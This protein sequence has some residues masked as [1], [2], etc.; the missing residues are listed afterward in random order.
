L[1]T[2]G[3]SSSVIRVRS[4]RTIEPSHDLAAET[5]GSSPDL[6][7]RDG[8]SVDRVSDDGSEPVGLAELLAALSLGI[9]LGFGQPMEHVLR[10]CRIALRI[11]E[12]LDLDQDDRGAVYYTALLINVGCHTDAFEQARWFGDDIALKSTKYD[13]EP[14]SI[15]DI[16]V[17]LRLLGSGGSPLHRVRVAFDFA[18]SGR[19]ELDG[20]IAGHAMAA[21]VLG[22]QLGLPDRVLVGL[23]GSYER[24]DG[25]GYP[26]DLSGNDVPIVSRISQL[27]EF[28][29]VAYRSGGI[30][31]AVSVAQR[32]S[33]KQFDPSVV[34]VVCA[35]AEKIFHGIE[36]VGSW[37]KV[38]DAEPA[39][40]HRLS[41]AEC[42]D[43]LAAIGRFVD[44]K[45]PYTLGHSGAVAELAAGA[46]EALGL[47]A[48]DVRALRRA[49]SVLGFGRLG[50]SNAIWDKPG[51]LS[52]SQ[53]ERV[54][55]HPY[56]TQR[57]LEQS[58]A[59][60]PVGRIASQVRER[61][62]GSGYPR[63]LSGASITRPARILAAA[64]TYQAMR[65][66]RPHRP[67]LDRDEAAQQLRAEVDAGRLDGEACGAVLRVAGHR[68][69]RRR[70]GPDGLTAREAEVLRL[71]ARGQSNKEVAATLGIAAKTAG[72]HVENIYAKIGIANRAEAS[73]YAVRHGLLPDESVAT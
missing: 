5:I 44:L 24:W 73:M 31:A 51:P 9:D 69:S 62:D 64:D 28:M 8:P 22:E 37:D 65:E 45:S 6:W 10:Q 52:G 3:M 25:R 32:R 30:E 34:D 57:M 16:A 43:A 56:F 11:A 71:I 13:Y 2:F 48:P 27:A 26:G 47:P 23:A 38:I 20:M 42:D 19:K 60:A 58:P 63:A 50:V 7:R 1:E 53:W 40:A 14:M 41:P 46:G 4:V 36:D 67:A 39:L 33:G 35:D 18:V 66:P 72:T 68:V 29:E 61:L 55:L 15:G 70:S 59:L 12:Q 17:T 49:G 54:R 21:R